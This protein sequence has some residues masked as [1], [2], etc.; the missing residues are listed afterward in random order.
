MQ[1]ES[2]LQIYH[3]VRE[4]L[5]DNNDCLQIEAGG[6][7]YMFDVLTL[8]LLVTI[9]LRLILEDK[10]VVKVMHDCRQDSA[11]LFYQMGIRVQNIFD[12][13]VRTSRQYSLKTMV[14]PDPASMT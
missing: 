11:A 1:L 6:T 8:G 12:T 7:C 5:L 2:L 3:C 14:K 10:E 13:Q 4:V 9:E